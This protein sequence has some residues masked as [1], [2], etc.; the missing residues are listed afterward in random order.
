MWPTKN[1]R[2]KNT[3]FT[4]VNKHLALGYWR[5]SGGKIMSSGEKKKIIINK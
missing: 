4:N 5:K 1:H 3:V 2:K